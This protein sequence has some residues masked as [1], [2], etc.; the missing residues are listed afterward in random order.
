M[1]LMNTRILDRAFKRHEY[2]HVGRFFQSAGLLGIPKVSAQKRLV[3]LV[4]K[5]VVRKKNRWFLELP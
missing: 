2:I 4:N 5:G 1:D 3:W